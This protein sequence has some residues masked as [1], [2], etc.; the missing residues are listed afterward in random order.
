MDEGMQ[1][2]TEKLRDMMISTPGWHRQAA[3]IILEAIDYVT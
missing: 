1:A 3:L 2:L